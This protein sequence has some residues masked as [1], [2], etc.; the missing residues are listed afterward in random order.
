MS[1]RRIYDCFG[2][3]SRAIQKAISHSKSGDT[4]TLA[5]V[6]NNLFRS[7]NRKRNQLNY[8]IW[9]RPYVGSMYFINYVTKS[10]N[11]SATILLVE[12]HLSLRQRFSRLEEYILGLSIVACMS[13]LIVLHAYAM[14]MFARVALTIA[15][16]TQRR[17]SGRAVGRAFSCEP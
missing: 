4:S 1:D 15:E 17:C 9:W 8:L 14:V 11:G 7:E 10:K 12:K 6:P 2:F 16:L 13:S 5:R 3:G